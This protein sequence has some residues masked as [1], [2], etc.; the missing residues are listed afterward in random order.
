MC[1]GTKQFFVIVSSSTLEEAK[2]PVASHGTAFLN[3]KPSIWSVFPFF[4]ASRPVRIWIG[5]HHSG[6]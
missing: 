3:R 2:T 5:Y 6:P 4:V 1:G